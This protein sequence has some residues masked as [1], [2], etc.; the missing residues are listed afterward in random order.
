MLLHAWHQP[1]VQGGCGADGVS[2]RSSFL[3]DTVGAVITMFLLCCLKQCFPNL[4][5]RFLRNLDN[6][7]KSSPITKIDENQQ[8]ENQRKFYDDR[9]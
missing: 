9:V 7:V 4:Q 6:K 3:L 2:F 1:A 5:D 8:D